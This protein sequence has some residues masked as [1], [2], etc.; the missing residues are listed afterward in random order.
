MVES[1]FLADGSIVVESSPSYIV[2][3]RQLCGRWQSFCIRENNSFGG[4]DDHQVELIVEGATT[5]SRA[6]LSGSHWTVCS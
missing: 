3:L 5:A 6:A 1:F 4:H 2:A